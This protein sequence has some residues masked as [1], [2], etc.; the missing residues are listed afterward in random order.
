VGGV[1]GLAADQFINSP[2]ICGFGTFSE[3]ASKRN[4]GANAVRQHFC[5][6][7]RIDAAEAPPH[8]TDLPPVHIAKI[9]HEIEQV[10]M[11]SGT[12]ASTKSQSPTPDLVAT[13]FQ[14]FAQRHCGK[15]RLRK[16]E[17]VDKWSFCLTTAI[18]RRE[19]ER[20]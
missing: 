19:Q 14:K 6:F 8:D 9:A 16:F 15:S 4:H 12:E 17:Q 13:S 11:N 1:H 2:S 18:N 3:W 7:A 5:E 20:P 10:V